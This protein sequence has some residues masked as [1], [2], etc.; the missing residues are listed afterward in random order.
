MTGPPLWQRQVNRV[1]GAVGPRV[2]SVTARDEFAIA[3]GLART[4]QGTLRRRYERESRRALH[5]LNLPAGTDV[6]ALRNQVASLEREVR[7][8][9]KVL[10]DGKAQGAP[11]ARVRPA[12]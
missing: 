8:L 1:V 4:V 11:R 5:L 6:R 3:V 9:G 12:R 2:E 10:H 7:D